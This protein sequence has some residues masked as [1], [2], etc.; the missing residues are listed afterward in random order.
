[1]DRDRAGRRA[2]AVAPSAPRRAAG[3]RSCRGP[4]VVE[5]RNISRTYGSRSAGAR[6]ARRRPRRRARRRDRDRRPVRL[7]QVDAAEHH[8][9]PGPAHRRA[10]PASTAGRRRARRGRARR[11]ARAAAGLRLSDVQPARP[12][13][14]RRERDAVGGLPRRPARRAPRAR[15]GGA[16]ARRRRAPRRLH[17]G[18]AV[19]RRAAARRDRPRADRR[20]EPAAVRR[21]DG[22]PR[23][24]QHGGDARALRGARR[25]RHD[26]A[27]HHARR[28]GRP[29]MPRRTSMVDGR[30]REHA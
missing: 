19:G 7:G 28:G 25:R 20:A 13:H 3:S 12:P 24:A 14:G 26:D 6:A 30:L 15:D 8:R 11:A 16:R 5:L 23:L 29:R 27:A 2:P 4:P 21:A 17:A 18:Q 10:L 9:L 22:Q 1:M